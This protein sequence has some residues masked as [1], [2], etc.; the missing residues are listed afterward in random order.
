MIYSVNISTGLLV[1]LFSSE[2]EARDYVAS[3]GSN[4]FK[5]VFLEEVGS[6]KYV[7][8]TVFS[9]GIYIYNNKQFWVD[10]A[11][12]IYKDYENHS[13]LDVLGVPVT[14]ERFHIEW[15]SNSTRITKI[16]DTPSEVAYNMEV[17]QE[18]IALFREKCITEEHSEFSG[19]EIATQ[20]AGLIPLLQTGSFKEARE[21]LAAFP[22][23]TYFTDE[24]LNHFYNMLGAAD[25]I[26]YSN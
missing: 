2:A 17:G 19:L 13:V 14:K 1:G 8:R 15:I 9:D 25:A 21:F 12:Y 5:Y 24:V 4:D 10:Q 7:S 26:T 11:P 6:M 20:I 23:N 18:L 22:R 3:F 16:I